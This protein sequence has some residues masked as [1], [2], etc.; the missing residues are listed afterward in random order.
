MT[1]KKKKKKFLKTNDPLKVLSG[2][3]PKL[4]IGK[5]KDT[6]KSLNIKQGDQIT[7][8]T[9]SG[10]QKGKM[11]GPY[12]PPRF[13]FSKLFF[14]IAFSKVNFFFFFFKNL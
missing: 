3:P 13:V 7:V 9:G 14:L 12:V 11:D 6:V 10:V 8:K 2:F 5:S 4:I 1:V